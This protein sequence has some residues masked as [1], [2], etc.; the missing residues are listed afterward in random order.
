[1]P[2]H[3]FAAKRRH[4]KTQKDE[5]YV[6]RKMKPALGKD[7]ISA[8]KDEIKPCEKTASETIISSFFRVASSC[9]F[10][11]AWRLFAWRNSVFSFFFF[12]PRK[13]KKMLSEKTPGVIPSF[14]FFL[15]ATKRQKDAMRKDARQKDEKAPPEKTPREK[16]PPREKKTKLK[17]LMASFCMAFFFFS[18]FRAETAFWQLSSFRMVFFLLFV[19]LHGVFSS[20]RV[21]SFRR[22]KTKWHNP[23]TKDFC[24][25]GH[26]IVFPLWVSSLTRYIL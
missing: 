13:D 15:F 9:L 14:L 10:L 20:F 2:F 25:I 6:K 23:A 19:F 16:T 7:E 22:K 18:S 21:V 24:H 4:A 5:K 12:S 3:L 17:F 26:T 1:M 8:R 11:F